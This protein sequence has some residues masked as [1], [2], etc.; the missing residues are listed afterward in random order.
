MEKKYIY[1]TLL[2]L[3]SVFLASCNSIVPKKSTGLAVDDDGLTD[4]DRD[5]QK[6][7]EKLK[8]N[9]NATSPEEI[10]ETIDEQE[11]AKFEDIENAKKITVTEG[12]LVNLSINA[13]D[14]DGDSLKVTFTKPLSSEGLWQTVI[15]DEGDYNLKATVS[16]GANVITQDILLV[17]LRKVTAPELTVSD[18]KVKEGDLVK[19]NAEVS[20]RG[21]EEVNINYSGPL[22]KDGKWQTNFENAGEYKIDVD[23]NAGKYKTKKSFTLTVLNVNRAP[24]IEGVDNE[25]TV[26]EGETVSINPEAIDEDGEEVSL[27]ISDPLGNDGIW[28]TGFEDA[29]EYKVIVSA[30]DGNEI[31][32]QTVLLKV[33][34][35]N[36]APTI[37]DI[38]LS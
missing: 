37:L 31:A 19:A 30:S 22:D 25:I 38:T 21:D 5:L 28:E 13:N 7:E 29:G 27:T 18:I 35:V 17:V 24:L 23:V 2:V 12:D 11:G 1:L 36:R 33:I 26:K 16:D 8:N 10:K 32:T 3:L 15:G 34:D 4:I 6:L 14:P 20:Y 9:E